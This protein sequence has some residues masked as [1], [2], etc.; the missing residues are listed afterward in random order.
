MTSKEQTVNKPE[1]IISILKFGKNINID[2]KLD[3]DRDNVDELIGIL[4]RAII[5]LHHEGEKL[6]V[7]NASLN[8][9]E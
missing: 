7:N 3:K 1:V 5:Y 4:H 9:M 6:L 2:I 8:K